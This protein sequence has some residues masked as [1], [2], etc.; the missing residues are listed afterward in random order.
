MYKL[1]KLTSITWAAIK[2]YT[3]CLFCSPLGKVVKLEQNV[4]MSSRE[5][6]VLVSLIQLYFGTCI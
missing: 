1:T 6:S 3:V 2:F 5:R 4:Q